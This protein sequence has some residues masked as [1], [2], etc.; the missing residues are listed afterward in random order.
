[1]RQP[2][3]ITEAHGNL[4]NADADALVNTVNTVGVMGKGIA[5]QF[6]RAFPEMFRAYKRAADAGEVELGR[7]HV[8]R[9]NAPTGP[10]YVINFPTKSHWKAKSRLDDIER[11]LHDLVKVIQELGIKSVA[12]PPL[13]CGHG[14]LA[15][16]E[17]APRI[18]AAMAQIPDVNVLLYPPIEA[19]MPLPCSPPH[20]DQK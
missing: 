2:E 8:W 13:G 15:W 19:P 7:M 3:M 12:V 6:R 14:G 20:S 4:L 11:G 16:S 5:L 17:V 1:M 18:L 10:Q 9:S